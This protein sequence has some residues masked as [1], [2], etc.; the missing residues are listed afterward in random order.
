MH[1]WLLAKPVVQFAT[2]LF[3]RVSGALCKTKTKLARNCSF[4]KRNVE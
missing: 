4:Y 2:S 3:E 1:N